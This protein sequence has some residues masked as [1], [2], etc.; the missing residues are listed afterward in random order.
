[1]SAAERFTRDK[2]TPKRPTGIDARTTLRHFAIVTYGVDPAA[3]RSHLPERFEP[4]CIPD[5]VRGPRAL[6]SAVP[7][8]DVDFRPAFC[9]WPTFTFGQTNYRAYVLDRET[10]EQVAWFFGTS[11]DSISVLVPRLA[12]KLPW[13]R[14]RI[15]FDCRYSSR[16]RRYERYAMS[17]KSEW[18]PVELELE[19]SGEPVDGLEGFPDLE[20]GLV[21]LTHPLRG[22]YHRRD[23][24]LGSYHIW[25]DRLELTVGS[26]RS[27]RFGLLDDLGLVPFSDQGSPH[28]VLLQHETDFF[29]Y[30]PPRVVG[31]P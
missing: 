4:V 12:W 19:D 9:P 20:H 16:D 31:A 18:A 15:R 29:I 6:V 10:N 27:A 22:F 30:L 14:A 1:M 28:S 17:T 23:G 8:L 7:F 25:H 3:L 24:R 2:L 13:Y 11:L 5:A 21:V 26:V